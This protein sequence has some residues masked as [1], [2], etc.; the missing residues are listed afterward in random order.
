MN[1]TDR[2][3]GAS[4]G[5]GGISS[6]LKLVGTSNAKWGMWRWHRQRGKWTRR[7]NK[8]CLRRGQT[9]RPERGQATKVVQSDIRRF[10]KNWGEGLAAGQ[11]VKHGT[12][13]K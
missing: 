7:T 13:M 4:N 2:G 3:G 10:G 5:R 8:Q 1:R 11:K 12:E 9:R 6:G